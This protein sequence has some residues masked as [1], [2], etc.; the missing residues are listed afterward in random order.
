MNNPKIL[1][2]SFA[3]S[4]SLHLLLFIIALFTINKAESDKKTKTY[5]VSLVEEHKA[6]VTLPPT[7]SE[8]QKREPQN[9]ELP[10]EPISKS[11]IN[12]RIEQEKIVKERIE[13]LEAKKK[14]E[15]IVALR[16]IVDIKESSSSLSKESQTQNVRESQSLDSSRASNLNDY[17]ALVVNKI[18]REWVY[19]E[20]FKGNLEAIVSIRI[21]SDGSVK[22]DRI[23]KSSGNPL[24]DR[25]ALRAINKASPL[26]PPPKELEVGIRF[27]P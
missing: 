27:N 17:Y 11:N 15:K 4:A 2:H 1:Y 6:P 12:K 25:Y 9:P 8:L 13:A 16:K 24:F 21:L 18:R 10:K 26:P 7:I 20:I 5:I 19:P 14:L 3:F 23:E 22:I